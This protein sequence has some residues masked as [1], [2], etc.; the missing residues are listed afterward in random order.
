MSIKEPTTGD[1][2]GFRRHSINKRGVQAIFRMDVTT[3]PCG[4]TTRDDLAEFRDK[5]EYPNYDEA[6]QAMLEEVSAEP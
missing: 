5:N 1:N 6:L 2:W 3:V 4:S